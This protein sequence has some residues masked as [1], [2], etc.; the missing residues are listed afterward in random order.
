L[1]SGPDGAA[2]LALVV[3]TRGDLNG[4]D[5]VYGAGINFSTGR[6][7]LGRFTEYSDCDF[8]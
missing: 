3:L 6:F 8:G 1:C 5:Q 2:Q 7:G 4:Y